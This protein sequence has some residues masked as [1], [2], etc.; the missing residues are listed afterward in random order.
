[1]ERSGVDAAALSLEMEWAIAAFPRVHGEA[2]QPYLSQGAS[3]S[4]SKAEQEALSL[5]VP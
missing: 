2:A 4:I 5:N 3:K 1:V